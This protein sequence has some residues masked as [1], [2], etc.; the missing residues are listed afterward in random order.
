MK[1][2]VH[3]Y[4]DGKM[5][6]IRVK[7]QQY[8]SDMPALFTKSARSQGED[9]IKELYK[10]TYENNTITCFGWYDGHIG[11]ENKHSL[12]PSGKSSFIE[13]D[14]SIQ[15]LY[16]DIFLVRSE[17]GLLVE[18]TISDYSMFY[19]LHFGEIGDCDSD[20]EFTE[21]VNDIPDYNDTCQE[22]EDYECQPDCD[23]NL[24]IDDTVY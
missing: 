16:G 5:D 24:E 13:D 14:S 12:P 10:W 8:L 2:A 6:E 1:S 7:T 20:S 19:N 4:K 17:G 11:F 3:I 23:I 18:F 21:T 15:M 22:E 9:V